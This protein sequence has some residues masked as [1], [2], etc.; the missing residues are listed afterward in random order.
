MSILKVREYLKEFGLED[1]VRELEESS[2]TVELAAL[3]LGITC[4]QSF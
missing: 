1:K 4:K 2:A 3:A